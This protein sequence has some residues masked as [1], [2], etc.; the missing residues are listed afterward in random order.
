MIY[1]EFKKA[2]FF[3]SNVFKKPLYVVEEID[4]F[5]QEVG[6]LPESFK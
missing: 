4:E 3:N 2:G 6:T 1:Q 5:E